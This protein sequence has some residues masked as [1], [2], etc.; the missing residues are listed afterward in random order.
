MLCALLIGVQLG[1]TLFR[2]AWGPAVT[3]WIGAVLAWPVLLV[4]AY[5]SMQLSRARWR[6]ALAWWMWSAALLFYAIGHSVSRGYDPLNFSRQGPFP[7]LPSVV[8]LLQY[9]FFFLAVL[10][11]P[12]TS[13]WESRWI[14][15]LDGLLLLGGAAA[16]SWY[17]ILAPLYMA[18]G[19]SLLERT[20]S[21][22]FPVGDLVVL[23]GLTLILLRPSR[24]AADRLVLSLLVVAIVCLIVADSWAAWHFLTA[25]QPYLAGNPSDLFWVP[26]YL[27]IP[28]AGLVQ[29]CLVHHVSAATGSLAGSWLNGQGPQRPDVIASLR[30]FLP[31][32]VAELASVLV[33][34]RDHEAHGVWTAVCD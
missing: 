30:L 14:M 23:F 18:S 7:T 10:L 33:L 32:V 31:I 26:C 8:Y 34:I 20:V 19:L 15:F 13:R 21:L 12:K 5:V 28:L 27:L 16:L 11:L 25:H 4:L 3:D 29:L 1:M 24:Y 6:D 17:F 2:P 9:P 22:A